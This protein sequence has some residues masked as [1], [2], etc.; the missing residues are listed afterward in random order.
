MQRAVAGYS[1]AL[2]AR[3]WVAN[4]DGNISAKLADDHRF[5]A[6]PTAVSKRLIRGHDVITVDLSG[7]VLAGR[8]RLFS[9]WSLH[10]A[11]YEARPDVRAV[12]HAHP[13]QATALGVAGVEV[14]TPAL[15][16]MV[17]S[18]G[19]NIPLVPYA[20][21]KTAQQGAAIAQALT[22]GAAEVLMIAGNGVLSVGVDLEQAYLRLELL[23]HYAGIV[24]LSQ[25]VGGPRP[26]PAADV[27]KLLDAR[28]RAGLG[29]KA[30]GQ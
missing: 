5:M 2:H 25:S 12:I 23:E 26:L 9:E 30:R 14:G 10:R 1:Q 16:E 28:T 20:M 3:G 13:P 22:K 27:E 21:P 11:A 6:T 7:K 15:P 19:A 8:L 24:L 17:V 18:L 4:H 29:K